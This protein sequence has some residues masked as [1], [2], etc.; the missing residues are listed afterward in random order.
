IAVSGN[1]Y[2]ITEFAPEHPGGAEILRDEVETAM[3]LCGMTDLMRDA[4]P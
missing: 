4:H 1:V 3:R 2:D